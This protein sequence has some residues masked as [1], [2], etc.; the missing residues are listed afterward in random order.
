MWG[1]NF[2]PGHLFI[3]QIY[4]IKTLSGKLSTNRVINFLPGLLFPGLTTIDPRWPCWTLHDDKDPHLFLNFL[5]EP[6][7]LYDGVLYVEIVFLMELFFSCTTCSTHSS[8]FYWAITYPLDKWY[9][10]LSTHSEPLTL[11]LTDMYCIS[12]FLRFLSS[13]DY[14][15]QI[16]GKC[17]NQVCL[18]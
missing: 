12:M 8:R 4:C 16:F 18:G 5:L 2:L 11:W 9:F 1:I 7:F 13:L 15:K 6:C 17:W 14:Q 10:M 3:G